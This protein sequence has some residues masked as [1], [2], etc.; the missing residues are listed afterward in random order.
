MYEWKKIDTSN[1]N[2]KA[3]RIDASLKENVLRAGNK[4]AQHIRDLH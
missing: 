2:G 1:K 4:R 3:R